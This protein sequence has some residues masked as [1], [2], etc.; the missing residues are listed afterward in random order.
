MSTAGYKASVFLAGTPAAVVAAACTGLT[1]TVFQI[2][3]EARR[4]IDPD[5]TILVYANGVL[6]AA[7]AYTLNYL[8]GKITFAVAPT[9]PVTISY[10]YVPLSEACSIRG[11]EIRH[12]RVVL[13]VTTFCTAEAD[14][15]LR[16]KKMGLAERSVSLDS[17][18]TS[19]DTSRGNWIAELDQTDDVPVVVAIKPDRNHVREFRYRGFVSGIDDMAEVEGLATSSINYTASDYKRAGNYSRDNQ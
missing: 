2:T 18:D 17:V 11:F 7:S 16:R 6:Q 13:D 1:S 12:E 10:S 15:G 5:A 14:G 4:V 9:A 8:F 3:N 19:G